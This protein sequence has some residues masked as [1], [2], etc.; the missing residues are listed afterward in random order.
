MFDLGQQMARDEHRDP[1]IGQGTDQVPHLNDAGRV[2]PVSGLVQNEEVGRGQHGG[3]D[4]QPLLHAQGVAAVGVA[5]A[6]QQADAV[7]HVGDDRRVQPPQAGQGQEVVPATQLGVE[8][9]GL[10]ECPHLVQIGGRVG[11]IPAQDGARARRR[12]DQ[13]QQHPD[14]RCLARPIGTHEAAHRSGRN[15][16]VKVVHHHAVAETLGQ[17]RG[18]DREGAARVDFGHE[19]DGMA[20][21]GTIAASGG[22]IRRA[23]FHPFG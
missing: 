19:D 8:G 13:A 9:R 16:Q 15:G 21:P 22:V 10:N 12:F 2:E 5:A 7:Q 18:L 6:R 3:R 4:A 11:Q 23:A 20:R 17:P 14:G 1:V